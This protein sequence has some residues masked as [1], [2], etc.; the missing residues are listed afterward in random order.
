MDGSVSFKQKKTGGFV[1]A[2]AGC[3]N[4]L[5]NYYDGDFQTAV[6]SSYKHTRDTGHETWLETGSCYVRKATKETK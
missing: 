2:H 1:H 6:R 4:A 3:N 5:C